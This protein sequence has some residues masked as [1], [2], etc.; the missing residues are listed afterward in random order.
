MKEEDLLKYHTNILLNNYN[1]NQKELEV[2]SNLMNFNHPVKE[3]IWAGKADLTGNHKSVYHPV[4]LM[5]TS[6]GTN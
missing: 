4:D 2:V 1:I 6:G 5:T 3:L